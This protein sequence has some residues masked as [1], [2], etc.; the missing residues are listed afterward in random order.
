MDFLRE[1]NPKFTQETYDL[2]KNNC[3]NFTD[4]CSSFLTGKGI[5]RYIVD[6]PLDILKTP[7]GAMINNMVSGM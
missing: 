7:M 4:E 6:L 2:F 5:P 3:N 1:I